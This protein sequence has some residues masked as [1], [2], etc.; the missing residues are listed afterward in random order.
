MNTSLLSLALF[1]A[2][3]PMVAAESVSPPSIVFILADDLGVG[4]VNSYHAGTNLVRTPSLDRLAREGRRFT[5]ANTPSSVC[6]PTRYAVLTGRYCWRT[7]L[8]HEV[9]GVGDPLWIE[10][11]R[12]TVA[13]L[14]K[15][16]GY[17][18]AAIGKWH[19]GYGPAKPVNYTGTLRPGPQ[20]VGFDYHFGVPSNH[21]DPTGIF[22]ENEGVMGLRSTNLAPFGKCYYGGKPFFG[23]DA[24]QREDES[25]M[26]TLTAKAVGWIEKLDRTRPFFLYFTPVAVHEPATPSARTKGTS[27]CGVYGDWIHELDL[28]VGRI[29]EALDRLKLA[30]NT[31]VIFTSD[32][33]GVLISDGG[34]RPEAKAYEAGMRV[35]GPWRGRKHSIYEGGFR[36]PFLARW[37]GR[38]P[39]GTVCD[40]T[41]NLVDT[42]ATTAAILGD[43][44]PAANAGA[45]DSF[46]VLPALLGEKIEKRLRPDMIVHSADGV[47]AIRQGP[48]KWIEGQSTKP[49][50]PKARAAEFRP[51]LYNLKNDPAETTDVSAQHPDVVK[52]LAALLDRY[53]DGGFSREL[54]PVSA[55]P[56]RVVTLPSFATKVVLTNAFDQVP[57]AP[58]VQVRGRW[59]ARDGAV[60]GTQKPSEAGPAALRGPLAQTDGDIRYEVW[61]LPNATHTLRLQC[62]TKEHVL[63]V[64]LSPG[65]LTIAQEAKGPGLAEA[66][67]KI[68]TGEWLPVH[69][70]TR[71][72]DLFVQV[73][74]TTAKASHAII[75]E[76][77]TAFALLG[78]GDGIGFRKVTV[79]RTSD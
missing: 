63:L 54:P 12:L 7:P 15:R 29:L 10:T 57:G 34:T 48:W 36:V 68:G 25:V 16:H 21:G 53:R 77:K 74:G 2:A 65:K 6:S 37:P 76:A 26:A 44:L 22:V 40:E 73:A 72:Q 66:R 45:E 79:T 23:I 17:Q 61:L 3:F 14:V 55:M 31:L 71:G 75:G 62:Q 46:N 64:Q 32:N 24:P 39:A 51:Q 20:E 9:L 59:V 52:N 30:E 11:N 8:K 42:L 41:I 47:F 13:S 70:C 43:K 1:L 33:G 49:Q 35:S 19:L 38:I 60:W 69:V 18:T 56:T 58:W 67:A 5:D 27:G 50:P 4:S 28:S 78:Y